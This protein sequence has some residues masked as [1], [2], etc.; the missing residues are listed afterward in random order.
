VSSTQSFT[1]AIILSQ[2][3][4]AHA[5]ALLLCLAF[6]DLGCFVKVMARCSPLDEA[7]VGMTK[8]ENMDEAVVAAE[9]ESVFEENPAASDGER[10]LES[11]D[12]EDTLS[13]GGTGNENSWTYYFRSST[14][15]VS[16]MIVMVEKGYFL[17][18]GACAPGVKTVLEP[19]NN[20]AVVYEDLFVACLRMPSHMALAD[21]LLHFQA[22]L[23]QLT[24][25][26][27]AQLS[28]YF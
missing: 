5:I 17:E 28:K 22:Q 1:I 16:K 13:E 2:C 14:I 10:H 15:T 19:D 24:P 9:L 3:A 11:P 25:N 21:I 12:A 23:H 27:I 26:A 18:D 6:D 8:V 4:H 20:E 7:A